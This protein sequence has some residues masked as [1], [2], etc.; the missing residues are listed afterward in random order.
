MIYF[1]YTEII[2]SLIYAVLYGVLFGCSY[3]LIRSVVPLVK[4]VLE[5]P[6]ESL[7]YGTSIFR[8]RKRINFE[9]KT[10][11]K[12]VGSVS[13]FSAIIAFSIGY[14]LLCYYTLDGQLR[15]Y[16]LVFSFIGIKLSILF[17][18]SLSYFLEFISILQNDVVVALRFFL[19]PMHVLLSLIK[20]YYLMLLRRIER[21]IPCCKQ[22]TKHID[23]NRK[24]RRNEG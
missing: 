5:I 1:T 17:K 21:Y 12:L 4:M 9:A 20:R 10:K 2:L 8:K 19:Y 14:I 16:L 6:R 23:H 3:Q 22:K 18:K 13:V 11:N 7:A 15:L 24:D